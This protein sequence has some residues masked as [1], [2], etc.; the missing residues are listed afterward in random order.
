MFRVFIL[1][2]EYVQDAR[3][4]RLFFFGRL[5]VVARSAPET[6]VCAGQRHFWLSVVVSLYRAFY[7]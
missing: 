5:L 7:P 3:K 4:T 6:R 1:V 2:K